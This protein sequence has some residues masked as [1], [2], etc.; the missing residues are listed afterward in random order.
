MSVR[1]IAGMMNSSL[2]A[3]ALGW[4][5][6]VDLTSGLKEALRFFGAL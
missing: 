5:P 1:D 4:R 3:S 2:A 6:E